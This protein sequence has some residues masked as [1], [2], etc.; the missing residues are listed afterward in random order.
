MGESSR[1]QTAAIQQYSELKA[2]QSEAYDFQEEQ[3]NSLGYQL[4]KMKKIKEAIEIFKLNVEAYPQSANVYD[5][6]AEAYMINGDKELAI[7]NYEKSIE[8]NPKNTNAAEML[9]KL[10]KE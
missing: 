9:K 1:F 6:L 10:K 2:T 8:L 5:S 7:E 3:L 4:L